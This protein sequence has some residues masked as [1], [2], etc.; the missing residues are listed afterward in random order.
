MGSAEPPEAAQHQGGVVSPAAA[1]VAHEQ[2]RRRDDG[3]GD[4]DEG[5]QGHER[6]GHNNDQD[7]QRWTHQQHQ[8]NNGRHLNGADH[9]RCREFDER[10]GLLEDLAVG[11]MRGRMSIPAFVARRLVCRFGA[12]HFA[13]RSAAVQRGAQDRDGVRDC[14]TRRMPAN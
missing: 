9:R 11:S 10:G 7:E 6:N 1:E 8:K 12:V 2:T 5:P 13:S 4:G 3:C 14:G